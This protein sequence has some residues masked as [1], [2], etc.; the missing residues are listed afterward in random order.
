MQDSPHDEIALESDTESTCSKATSDTESV[1]TVQ[2]VR[3]ETLT[4]APLLWNQ[5]Q[6]L[7]HK[8][9][10]HSMRD[11]RYLSTILIFPT[12]LLAL[13]MGLGLLRPSEELPPLLLTPST[14]GP[15]S[16]SFIQ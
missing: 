10:L 4:G 6:G 8:R 2:L 1:A 7:L 13:S 11:W 9:W 3:K 5:I 15:F 12:L 14:Y 16:N